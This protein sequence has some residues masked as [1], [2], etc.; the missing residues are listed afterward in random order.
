MQLQ[1]KLQKRS[2]AK[3]KQRTRKVPLMILN[4]KVLTGR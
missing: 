1:V 3:D 4:V 2:L